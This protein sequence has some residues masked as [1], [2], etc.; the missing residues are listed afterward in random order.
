M[1][2]DD[3]RGGVGVAAWR[4]D[5]KQVRT[6]LHQHRRCQQ[7]SNNGIRR[8]CGKGKVFHKPDL[9]FWFSIVFPGPR[10]LLCVSGR[11]TNERFRAQKLAFLRL[12]MSIWASV[13]TTTLAGEHNCHGC[14]KFVC[15]VQSVGH[16]VDLWTFISACAACMK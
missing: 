10:I 1:H 13:T 4:G 9:R 7:S 12:S 5:E 2:N 15:S 3:D 8:V 14:S 16:S 6:D 11:M